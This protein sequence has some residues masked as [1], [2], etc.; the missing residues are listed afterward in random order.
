[1][2]VIEFIPSTCSYNVYIMV[3]VKITEGD[4]SYVRVTS[5]LDFYVSY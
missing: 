5:V 1:M 2:S 4:K 3:Y